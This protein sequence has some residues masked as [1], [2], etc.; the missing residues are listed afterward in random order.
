MLNIPPTR[1]G[2][3]HENDKARLREL[4]AFLRNAFLRMC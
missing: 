3:F 2:R 4:G 1:E